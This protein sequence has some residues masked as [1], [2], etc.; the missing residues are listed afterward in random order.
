MSKVLLVSYVG[1][2]STPAQLVANPW[3]ATQLAALQ[4]A[5]HDARALDYGTVTM[6]RRLYPEALTARLKPMVAGMKGGGQLD[7]NGLRMLQDLDRMLDAHQ[8]QVAAEV[9]Q[10]LLERIERDRPQVVVFELG[11]GDG[12]TATV[13]MAEAVRERFPELLIAAGGRK[14]AW[15][16]GLIH[17]S[18]RA[19]DAIIHGDPET[20]VVA[21]AGLQSRSGLSTVPGLTTAEG[22]NERVETGSLDD[23]PLA[24]YDPAVYPAMAGDDKIKMAIISET[25]GCGNRCAFCSHPWE[26]GLH[27]RQMSPNRLV[28]TMQGLQERYGMS[29]F[30]YGG[31]S[32]P[33]ELMYEAAREILRRGLQVQYNSFGHYRTAWPEH[34]E[35][36]AKSGL[37]SLFFGLE[38][39][40]QDILDKAVH[41]GIK[42][43]Q[44]RDTMQAARGAGIFAAA[45]MIVPLPFDDEATLAESL[46]FITELRP[47]SVP[48]QFPGLMPGSRWIAD[49]ARYNIE[50]GD[51]EKFLLDGLDYKFKL[52]FPPQYWQPL[53]YKVNGM[54]FHEFTGVTMKFGMQ[55]EMAG[56]LTNFSHTLAAIAK[57][58]GLPPRQLR[59]LAQLWCVTGDAEGMGEMIAR[60]NAAMV[61]PH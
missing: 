52:L 38:S 29:V 23:L 4:A 20:V 3:L 16:R 7:E 12:Y 42:L 8:E 33:A 14:A 50:V 13:Q 21:L 51:T 34:F 53:P 2:P 30:R 5:G 15:F 45:S 28:D 55:L 40:S 49:P 19:F 25:R 22:E 6:M 32:T 1:Y 60:A 41:K 26:D 48:L 37:Y 56:L 39:G 27:Q 44:V 18:T 11:D 47:D 57:S 54:S 35:T 58:A 43:Q 36:L 10:E 59:D 46:Q 9:R 24:V 17:K 31:A 61:R